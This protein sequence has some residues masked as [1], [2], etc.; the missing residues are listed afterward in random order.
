MECPSRTLRETHTHT[1]S[2]SV[3]FSIIEKFF[4]SSLYDIS[5]GE[6]KKR[7]KEREKKKNSIRF[8]V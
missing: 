8:C 6:E 4:S 2:P 3:L 1:H 5:W 7:D